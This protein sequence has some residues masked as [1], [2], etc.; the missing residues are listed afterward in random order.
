MQHSSTWSGVDSSSWWIKSNER[1]GNSGSNR[2]Q[3]MQSN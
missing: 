3:R 2:Q 1:I